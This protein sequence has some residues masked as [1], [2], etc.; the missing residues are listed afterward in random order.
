MEKHEESGTGK[1]ICD[2]KKNVKFLN[3]LKIN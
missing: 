1:R 3:V 2:R